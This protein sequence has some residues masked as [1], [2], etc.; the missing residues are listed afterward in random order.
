M[1]NVK[2]EMY[3]SSITLKYKIL[4]NSIKFA[5]HC[6]LGYRIGN[7]QICILSI[8]DNA[9]NSKAQSHQLICLACFHWYVEQR[10]IS[11]IT[12]GRTEFISL[13]ITKNFLSVGSCSRQ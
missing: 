5:W 6:S 10:K 8:H 12:K 9:G 3:R 11:A 4:R 1:N 2:Y 7:M 13:Q